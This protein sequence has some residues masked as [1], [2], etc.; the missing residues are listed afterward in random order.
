MMESEGPATAVQQ[1]HKD[2]IDVYGQSRIKDRV[3]FLVQ[4]KIQKIL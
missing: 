3:R 4:E 1:E 2:N